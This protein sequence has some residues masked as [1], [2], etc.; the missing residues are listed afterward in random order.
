MTYALLLHNISFM[1][2]FDIN[3]VMTL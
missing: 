2:F 3:I 1:N